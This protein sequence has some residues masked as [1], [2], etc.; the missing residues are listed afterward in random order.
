MRSVGDNERLINQLFDGAAHLKVRCELQLSVGRS[1]V[2][3]ANQE[4]NHS[5]LTAEAVE[6]SHMDIHG[7]G[8]WDVCYRHYEW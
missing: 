3:A 5:R 4:I 2:L 6:Y 8:I 1:E 7:Y